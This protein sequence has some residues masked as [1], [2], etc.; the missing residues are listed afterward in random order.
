[1]LVVTTV[2]SACSNYQFKPTTSFEI[3]DFTTTDHRSEEVTLESLKGEPWLAMFI[4]TNCTSICSPMTYNMTLIQDEL[5]KKGVEDYKI[6][7][8]SIDPAYDTPERLTEYLQRHG[9]PDESKWHMLTGY[10]QK[11][12]EQFAAG[13]FKTL[14]KSSDKTDQVTHAN[15]FYLVDEEGIAVKNYTGYSSTEGGVPYETIATDVEALIKERLT[16]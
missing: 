3:S 4:F 1:M 5:I 2:L 13:S 9:A 8:F 11:F 12:I 15:T 14:V 6:V 10:D 16:K 7:A